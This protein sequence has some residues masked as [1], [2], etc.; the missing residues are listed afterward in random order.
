MGSD[1]R[2]PP[3]KRLRFS[4]EH[5]PTFLNRESRDRGTSLKP[6]EDEFSFIR[7]FSWNI[8]GIDPFLQKPITSFFSSSISSAVTSPSST[9]ALNSNSLSSRPTSS[10]R[11][12]LRRHSWP[13]LLC[14]QEVKIAFDDT[15]TQRAVRRAVNDDHGCSQDEPQYEIFFTLPNDKFNARGWGGKVYGVCSIVRKDFLNERVERVRDVDWDQEGRI[16]IVELKDKINIWNVYAVNGTDNPWRHPQSGEIIGTRH[17]KK[18]ELHQKM[19]ADCRSAAERGISFLIIGDL[20]V[21]PSRIDGHPNLR[22]FPQQHVISRADFNRKFFHSDNGLRAIDVWRHL[23]GSERKYTY[24]PR[25]KP[26]ASSCDRV[27]L[28]ISSRSL[29]DNGHVTWIEI[30]DSEEERGPSDHVPIAVEIRLKADL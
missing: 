30:F 8:N 21:A 22:T 26:W 2:L 1:I 17:D 23:R 18:R 28:V 11:A 24:F 13:H 14:L 9:P 7:I 3:R 27:D 4:R 6:L 10:L 29:M 16:M 12:F 25:G 19:V 15:A 5:A 20:N